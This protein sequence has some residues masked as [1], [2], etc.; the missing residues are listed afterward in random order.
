[1]W[2]IYFGYFFVHI[3]EFPTFFHGFCSNFWA[4]LVVF[5][6]LWMV[7]FRVVMVGGGGYG[8]KKWRCWKWW[9]MVVEMVA[10]G[11]RSGGVVGQEWW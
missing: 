6:L 7:V 1:M 11:G 4:N 8:R 10:N 9:R 5:G 3:L 2:L